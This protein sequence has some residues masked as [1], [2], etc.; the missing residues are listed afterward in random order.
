MPD[1]KISWQDLPEQEQ[2]FTRI[3]NYA[4]SNLTTFAKQFYADLQL[5]DACTQQLALAAKEQNIEA[6][7]RLKEWTL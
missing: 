4:L 3:I 2:E 1:P 6:M 5:F 7:F